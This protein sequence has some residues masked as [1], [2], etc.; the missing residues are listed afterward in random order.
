MNVNF[1]LTDS[2]VTYLYANG[3]GLLY[4]GGGTYQFDIASSS[5]PL[6][7]NLFWTIDIATSPSYAMVPTVRADIDINGTN[8]VT[9]ILSP[10]SNVFDFATYGGAEITIGYPTGATG[11][12]FKVTIY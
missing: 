1:Q 10:G 6:I 4:P 5:T 8:Y 11:S 12:E 9:A 2:S 7:N 3:G